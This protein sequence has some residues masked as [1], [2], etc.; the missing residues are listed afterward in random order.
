MQR[1]LAKKDAEIVRQERE[2]HKLRVSYRKKP[3]GFNS[4]SRLVAFDGVTVTIWSGFGFLP[5][6]ATEYSW[7]A[8]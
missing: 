1:K 8:N 4:L 6:C 3:P 5:P 2:L 7:K